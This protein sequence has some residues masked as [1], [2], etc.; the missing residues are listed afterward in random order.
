MYMKG[1]MNTLRIKKEKLFH[2]VNINFPSHFS[3]IKILLFSHPLQLFASA[4]K[5][6]FKVNDF[7][8]SSQVNGLF[9]SI[10]LTLLEFTITIIN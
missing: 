2:G 7:L 9:A 8:Q 4:F 10:F 5:F 1:R 3:Q 6:H